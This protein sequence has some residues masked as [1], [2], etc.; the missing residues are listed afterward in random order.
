MGQAVSNGESRASN[1]LTDCVVEGEFEPRHIRCAE[2]EHEINHEEQ[3]NETV[4]HVNPDR[5]L[6]GEA[7]AWQSSAEH[8][9]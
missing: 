8:E 2:V 5:C 9:S 6:I 4:E 1:W 3:I 7:T